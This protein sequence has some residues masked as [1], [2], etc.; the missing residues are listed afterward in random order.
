MKNANIVFAFALL[1]LACTTTTTTTSTT[2]PTD[3]GT[4]DGGSSTK[5][6]AASTKD[7][8][9]S[10]KGDQDADTSDSTCGDTTDHWSCF[11]CCADE[12]PT[13]NDV[14]Q[15]AIFGCYCKDENC[16]TE[17]SSTFCASN[18]NLP[19]ATCSSC[20]DLHNCGAEIIGKCNADTDC[21]AF[22]KCR[23][24]SGCDKKK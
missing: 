22:S 13:G 14:Y 16:K 5:D 2:P 10:S 19:D 9:S 6:A 21:V 4:S 24:D 18:P 11:S 1:A 17:C 7:A 12:H 23:I 8:G 15:A 20:L 3:A